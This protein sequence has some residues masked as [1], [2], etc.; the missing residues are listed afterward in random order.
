MR[1]SQPGAIVV[2]GQI[3]I[4]DMGIATRR[5]GGRSAA[6]RGIVHELRVSCGVRAREI[7]NRDDSAFADIVCEIAGR[8]GE[9]DDCL[10]AYV[11][12]HAVKASSTLL[13]EQLLS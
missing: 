13:V 3:V 10:C 9:A 2:N 6:V 7:S 4:M 5:W 12:N 8:I 11:S 1:L